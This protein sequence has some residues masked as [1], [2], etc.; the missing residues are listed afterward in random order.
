LAC[1]AFAS[2]AFV[3]SAFASFTPR[4]VVSSQ[5]SAARIGVAA[6]NADD[7][8]AK[9][10]FYIPSAYQVGAPT[11]GTKLGDV[12]ATAAAADL[13]GAVLPLT[14]ELDAIAPTATTT[15]A[16]QQCGVAPTQTWDLHL[17]AAG[18][19]LD[20]PMF[21]VAG[22]ANEVAAGYTTKLVVCLP[23]P[24]VPAGTPGR[25]VFGA[26]LLS[27]TFTS[28]AITQPST[29]GDYRWTSIWTP[30][31][32]GKGTPNAAGTVESQ[33]TRHVPVAL[34]LTTTK[35]K[36]TK[37]T[38]VKVKGKKVKRKKVT[39]LVKWSATAT[40]N[41]AAPS[42]SKVATVIAGTLVSGKKA[43]GASG[44]FVLAS[45]KSATIG[46]TATINSDTGS[47]PTG[48][49]ANAAAD[50]WYHD[51]GSGACTPTTALTG[52]LP[53]INATVGGDI[54]KATAKVVGY[55]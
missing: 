42:S 29:A 52:G 16:A 45:G 31:T 27:A 15:A 54:L 34:K 4:L 41:S 28:S 39:T 49:P 7:P 35:T 33:S 19:T 44:S 50:L 26:K 40:A 55:K 17:T 8:S 10:S 9:A 32:P 5:G 46:S 12:T 23:P 14:G 21:V 47:I 24:D 25:A 53:C 43:G 37:T 38:T 20:I 3:G 1:A 2:L 11:P 6:A 51:L 36:V 22:A 18:Q 13:G 30:Y 48:Q